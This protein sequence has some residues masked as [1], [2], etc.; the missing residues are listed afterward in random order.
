[1]NNQQL[2]LPEKC[3]VGLQIRQGTYTGKLGYIIY[4]DGKVWRKETSWESW[5]HK[6]GKPRN[7]WNPTTREYDEGVYEG[8]E[9]IVFDNI[10]TAGFVL[11]K[12]AGG[13]SSGWNHRQTY[14]RVY[15]PRGWEFEITVPN[16]LYILQECNS[17]KG[18]GLEGEFVYSWDGKDLVLLPVSSPDYVACK[19]Y[20]DL[21]SVK[22]N[23]REDLFEGGTYLT[24]KQEELV[25]LGRYEV[26][27]D[28]Y[29]NKVP[30]EIEDR[31]RRGD[32]KLFQKRHVFAKVY[33]GGVGY[34]FLSGFSRIKM[35]V[36]DEIH[37]EFANLVDKF[38]K[39]EYM[40]VPDHLVI[41]PLKNEYI[42]ENLKKGWGYSYVYRNGDINSLGDMLAAEKRVKYHRDTD[43]YEVY[44]H[45]SDSNRGYGWGG[46][47]ISEGRF[48]K[49]ELK[50]NYGHL[51]RV[52]NNGFK[53]Q[54]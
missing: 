10:P 2:Y 18:K 7:D 54:V 23:S 8:V 5:R 21:Q 46:S 52:Y 25:Y 31:Y 12:K 1:M 11:N 41:E 37:P 9:P 34:E 15:D 26:C 20:T 40:G 16:L 32:V 30:F 13:Y 24:N 33:E 39:S 6:E 42:E 50:Q 36:N 48:S 19:E 27:T 17:Y 29:N 44:I 14:S 43:E 4:H 49:K 47:D 51:M 53:K 38:L 45:R 35:K 28:T 3:K 22:F